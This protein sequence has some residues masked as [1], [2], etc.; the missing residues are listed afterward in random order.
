MET[1]LV[2]LVIIGKT[3]LLAAVS[4]SVKSDFLEKADNNIDVT[5][6]ILIMINT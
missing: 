2:I 4:C 1:T 6:N 5:L 3:N